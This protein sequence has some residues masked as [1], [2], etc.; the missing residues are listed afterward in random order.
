MSELSRYSIGTRPFFYPMHLQPVFNKA[1]LFHNERLP[2]S[3]S[4]YQRG[5]YI[6]SGI[7]ITEMQINE[8]VSCLY[9]V[10]T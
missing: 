1:G 3:E 2:N 6:P 4:L 7:A 8:V 5:F 9:K 10:L